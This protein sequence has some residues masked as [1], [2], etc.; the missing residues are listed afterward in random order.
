M[1]ELMAFSSAQC[2]HR[3][4]ELLVGVIRDDLWGPVLTVGLGGIWTEILQD[5][6]IRILPISYNEIEK[7]LGELRGAQLL[8]GARGQ[9][10]V[11]LKAVNK[12]IYRIAE[13]ALALGPKLNALEINPLL[14]KG[15]HIEA[16]DV[17]VN[18]L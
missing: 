9:E 8:H 12:V 7:M 14:V 1:L 16:L 6:A 13:L 5:T 17:L 3:A 2:V 15:S 18:W 11:D 10:G 4:L